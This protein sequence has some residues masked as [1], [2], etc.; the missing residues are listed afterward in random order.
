M[1]PK[2][3]LS[4]VARSVGCP[5]WYSV[6]GLRVVFVNESFCEHNHFS[7]IIHRSSCV[8]RTTVAEQWCSYIVSSHRRRHIISWF[9][10]VH[11]ADQENSS[12]FEF[13]RSNLLLDTHSRIILPVEIVLTPF[14]IDGGRDNV[15][16]SS[17]IGD[18]SMQIKWGFAGGRT[19]TDD[20]RSN[21]FNFLIITFVLTVDFLVR[22]SGILPF[23]ARPNYCIDMIIISF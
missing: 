21:Q 9:E 3:F 2:H 7:V 18:W 12:V 23:H 13:L 10:L 20:D 8:H 4:N 22:W 6:P 11:K 19:A 15:A 17:G 14:I 1:L 5:A 16:K